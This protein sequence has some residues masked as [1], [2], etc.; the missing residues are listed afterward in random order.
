MKKT[1]FSTLMLLASGAYANDCIVELQFE[2]SVLGQNSFMAQS[3]LDATRE[4][5]RTQKRYEMRYGFNSDELSCV[6]LNGSS[7][8]NG[9]YQ[10]IQELKHF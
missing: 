1:L 7:T 8:G 10:H 3:C 4:C 6:R 2:G 5:K 9:G